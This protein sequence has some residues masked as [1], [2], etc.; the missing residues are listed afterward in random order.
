MFI[1]SESSSHHVVAM[2]TLYMWTNIVWNKLIILTLS[3]LI[4]WLIFILRNCIHNSGHKHA[5]VREPCHLQMS[6]T[7]KGVLKID[8][9]TVE[10]SATESQQFVTG[11][12]PGRRS[13]C[14]EMHLVVTLIITTEEPLSKVLTSRMLP[15]CSG[16]CL[17]VI[18][19]IEPCTILPKMLGCWVVYCCVV[20]VDALMQTLFRYSSNSTSFNVERRMFPF[21]VHVVG[22]G[23]PRVDGL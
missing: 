10:H 3:S 7:P 17:L 18:K 19:L 1:Q 9:G 16:C 2:T 5:T 15:L 20:I 14:C 8:K 4:S 6:A 13:G 23:R 21:L 22:Q 12:L 11:R